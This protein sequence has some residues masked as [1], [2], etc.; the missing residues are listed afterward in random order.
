MEIYL[1][2]SDWVD[3][4]LSN[5]LPSEIVAVNFN[6]SE[7]NDSVYYIQLVGCDRFDAE[8]E[9]WACDEVFSTEEDYFLVPKTDII[10][11]QEQGLQFMKSLVERYLVDG[12]Y[13]GRLKNYVA[14]SVGFVDG[15]LIR[16]INGSG[17]HSEKSVSKTSK[18][19]TILFWAS[20]SLYLIPWGM[21]LD[22]LINGS[23]FLNV[24]YYGWE[25]FASEF[26]WGVVFILLLGLPVVLY[27][28]VYSIRNRRK[29]NV[30]LKVIIN[31]FLLLSVV[32][33]F[34]ICRTALS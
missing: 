26:Q 11:Q 3:K 17:E 18:L 34:R 6:L 32:V 15:N 29:K 2:F 12:K 19:F 9:D 25:A 8:D 4:H 23:G 21:G 24:K 10:I 28:V 20:L 27:Q 5:G 22:G 13:S 31:A 14:V 1:K 33:M 16:L 30:K 7:G